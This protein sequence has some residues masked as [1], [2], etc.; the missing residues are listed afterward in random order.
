MTLVWNHFL[1][2]LSRN[3][4]FN[5]IKTHHC[6]SRLII[7]VLCWLKNSDICWSD[8]TSQ[9][10]G[11]CVETSCTSA[12]DTIFGVVIIEDKKSFPDKHFYFYNKRKIHS[13]F[14]LSNWRNF[15]RLW[16]S[17]YFSLFKTLHYTN[18]YKSWKICMISALLLFTEKMNFYREVVRQKNKTR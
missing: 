3:L 13:R 11:S 12:D 14:K 9:Q 1:H 5:H 16:K 7:M 6:P 10:M 15:N 8:V 2:S 18:K 17:M 4:R